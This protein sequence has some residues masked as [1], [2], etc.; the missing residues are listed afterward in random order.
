[1]KLRDIGCE[2]ELLISLY[3]VDDYK[4]HMHDTLMLRKWKHFAS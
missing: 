2:Y 1:M 3:F 4:W